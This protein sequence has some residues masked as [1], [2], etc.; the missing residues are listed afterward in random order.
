MAAVIA[1]GLGTAKLVTYERQP[2]FELRPI[3]EPFVQ[4]TPGRAVVDVWM[5]PEVRYWIEY[6]D[7]YA[8][9]RDPWLN[10]QVQQTSRFDE[11]VAED[12]ESFL[13]SKNEALLL[14]N[15]QLIP[16][17]PAN[18]TILEAERPGTPGSDE[19]PVLILKGASQAE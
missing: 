9:L 2:G 3:L 4:A 6:S 12:L 19:P 16:E 10:L 11:A 18:T 8:D 1:V 7:R 17:Q 14:R 15:D 13:S 5:Y